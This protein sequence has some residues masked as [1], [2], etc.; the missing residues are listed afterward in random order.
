MPAKNKSPPY[1]KASLS[2]AR[3]H[4]PMT[5]S[6]QHLPLGLIFHYVRLSPWTSSFCTGWQGKHS[7]LCQW[8][9]GQERSA[10]WVAMLILPSRASSLAPGLQASTKSKDLLC[11]S[12]DAP[13]SRQGSSHTSRPTVPLTAVP[14]R[15]VSV[16]TSW[17][18]SG[19]C[20]GTDLYRFL[21]LPQAF[22]TTL[23][24]TPN[25]WNS[26][27]LLKST[28]VSFYCFATKTPTADTKNKLLEDFEIPAVFVYLWRM[29]W[30]NI[31][32]Y[33][34]TA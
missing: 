31:K 24:M 15:G 33:I 1:W 10:P 20:T 4:G 32:V 25:L 28:R 34:Q 12:D 16:H 11:D 6:S 7:P 19:C 9:P 27:F 2:H 21:C 3:V 8:D 30:K 5:G 17:G 29:T 22:L 18:R 13:A 26:F 23:C 14:S